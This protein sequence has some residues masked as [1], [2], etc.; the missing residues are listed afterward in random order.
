MMPDEESASMLPSVVST[1]SCATVAI[2]AGNEA[3]V[4]KGTK[5]RSRTC[6]ILW[7][8]G[9]LEF[10]KDQRERSPGFYSTQCQS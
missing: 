6:L 4:T 7:Y 5:S 9:V 8:I 10:T 1:S 2:G 3:E